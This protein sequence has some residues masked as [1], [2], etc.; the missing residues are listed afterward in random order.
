M[1]AFGLAYLFGEDQLFTIYVGTFAQYF[2]GISNQTL[3]QADQSNYITYLLDILK[4][5]V[6]TI[7]V[8]ILIFLGGNIYVE[9][10][11]MRQHIRITLRNILAS[12]K[13][14]ASTMKMLKS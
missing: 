3:L 5:I 6:N 8:A 11:T 2:F 14:T 1:P 13:H 9:T 10:S 4:T 12:V 7:C